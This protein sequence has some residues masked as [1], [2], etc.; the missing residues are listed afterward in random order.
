MLAT[1]RAP[2][3]DHARAE[4]RSPDAWPGAADHGSARHGDDRQVLLLAAERD[5][6]PVG[7]QRRHGR[8]ADPD[9]AVG[10]DGFLDSMS[11]RCHL[12]TGTRQEAPPFGRSRRHHR[13]AGG[14]CH[15]G[16][17]RGHAHARLHLQRV[18]IG[19]DQN[20]SL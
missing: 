13:D 7:R 6:G 17:H 8:A 15:T 11:T 9:L 19:H 3:G 14:G 1:S 20:W 2:S 5:A 18:G 12:V 4:T 10:D 16:G